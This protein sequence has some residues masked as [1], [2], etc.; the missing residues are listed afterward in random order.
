MIK[1]IKYATGEVL[2]DYGCVFISE[3]IPHRSPSGETPR[4]A[5]FLCSCGDEFESFISNVKKNHTK[6]C[7]CRQKQVASM[8]H[9]KHGLSEH[10]LH[11]Q[12]GW[13]KQRCYNKNVAAYK[14]YGGRGIT[15]CA[16]WRYD[17]KAFYDY[18]TQLDNYGESG[19]TLDRIDNDGNYEPGNMRWATRHEQNTNQRKRKD[20]KSGYIGVRPYNDK[21]KWYSDIR[22][23]GKCF[24]LGV[25]GTPEHA[26]IAR[27]NFIIKN[28]LSEYKIQS[29]KNSH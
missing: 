4:R 6:S 28:G 26:V 16:E 15:I 5:K 8:I 12:W 11:A 22:V 23:N 13:I 24:Y 2:G 18:V 29:L 25:Y 1:K 21:Q 3:S 27:N 14:H 9:R 7:G 19:M 10:P 20:N 17:F